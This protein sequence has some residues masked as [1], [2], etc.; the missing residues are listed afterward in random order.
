MKAINETMTS[1]RLS[2]EL[3]ATL[4]DLNTLQSIGS[5]YESLIST[6]DINEHLELAQE[7]YQ[8]L[9][10]FYETWVDEEFRMTITIKSENKDVTFTATSTGEFK[11]LDQYGRWLLCI[12]Y[13]TGNS[14]FVKMI[15]N[16]LGEFVLDEEW[17][18]LARVVY[19]DDEPDGYL[20]AGDYD[21]MPCDED[22]GACGVSCFNCVESDQFGSFDLNK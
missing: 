13:N 10:E 1:F 6:Q 22:S 21:I 9:K 3:E 4:E 7:E 20:S 17:M 5:K 16:Q 18:E 12:N 19:L 11:D 2:R 15:E 8:N 14:H